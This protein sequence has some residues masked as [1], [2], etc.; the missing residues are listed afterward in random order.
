MRGAACLAATLLAAGLSVGPLA[1]RGLAGGR[2]EPVTRLG[3]DGQLVTRGDPR[4]TEL[5]AHVYAQ[6]QKAKH[7]TEEVP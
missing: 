2:T 5:R 7:H 6:I 1:A 3:I 4:F